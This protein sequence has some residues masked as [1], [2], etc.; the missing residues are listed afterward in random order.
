MQIVPTCCFFLASQK[1]KEEDNRRQMADKAMST[2]PTLKQQRYDRQLRSVSTRERER[3]RESVC[4]CVCVC[5]C[6]LCPALLDYL[7]LG[8]QQRLI[9]CCSVVGLCCGT[10]ADCG[11]TMDRSSLRR[12]TSV[13]WAPPP[14]ALRLS[15]TLCFQVPCGSLS[16]RMKQPRF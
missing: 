1:D 10:D 2:T 11:E 8:C 16:L 6:V 5:V 3:E 12:P 7:Y 13:L 4:V 9:C 15:R 14:S